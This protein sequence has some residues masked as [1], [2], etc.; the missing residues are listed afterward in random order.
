M[1][2]G[3]TAYAAIQSVRDDASKAVAEVKGAVFEVQL[4]QTKYEAK[5]E[6]R[7]T[8]VGRRVSAVEDRQNG[9]ER[10]LSVLGISSA[11]ADDRRPRGGR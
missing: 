1:L 5:D 7:Q 6:H 11:I 10:V 3:W 4:A 9:L 2:I 8:E